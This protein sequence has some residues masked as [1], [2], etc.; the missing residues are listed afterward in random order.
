MD[1]QE[2]NEETTINISLIVKPKKKQIGGIRGT[3]IIEGQDLVHLHQNNT[4]NKIMLIISIMGIE[5]ID[6]LTVCV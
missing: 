3:N 2:E 4:E 5:S 1:R 6:I